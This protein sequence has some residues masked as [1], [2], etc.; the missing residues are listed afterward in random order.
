MDDT[1]PELDNNLYNLTV[2]TIHDL[3]IRFPIAIETF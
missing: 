3:L 2:K 1:I